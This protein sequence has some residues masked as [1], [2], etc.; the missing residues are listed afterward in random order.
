MKD[1]FKAYRTRIMINMDKAGISQDNL[2][3]PG[4]VDCYIIMIYWESRANF[5]LDNKKHS[6]GMM[7]HLSTDNLNETM[8]ILESELAKNRRLFQN[9]AKQSIV[10]IHKNIENSQYS[11]LMREKQEK[12][13]QIFYAIICKYIGRAKWTKVAYKDRLDNVIMEVN[14][15]VWHSGKLKGNF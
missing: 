12:D 7:L 8:I 3:T 6:F 1:S 13:L 15:K 11:G 14:S 4:D 9:A 2:M 10:I 5:G